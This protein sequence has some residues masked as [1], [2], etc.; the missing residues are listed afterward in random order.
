MDLSREK[1]GAREVRKEAIAAFEKR[2][3]KVWG[4]PDPFPPTGH[5]DPQWGGAELLL[6]DQKPCTVSNCAFATACIS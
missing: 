1:E 4:S 6:E 5:L 3:S 2:V